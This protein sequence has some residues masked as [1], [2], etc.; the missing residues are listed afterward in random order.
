M[1]QIKVVNALFEPFEL[2]GEETSW[3]F[4]VTVTGNGIM[5]RAKPVTARVGD[6]RMEG[7]FILPEEDGFTG[8][9]PR[10]PDPGARLFVAYLDEPEADTDVVYVP[11]GVG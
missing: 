1:P 5:N 6:I 9:L 11:L 10:E 2:Q 8:F 4:R 7:I 3:Q